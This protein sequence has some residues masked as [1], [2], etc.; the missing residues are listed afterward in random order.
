MPKRSAI[1][2]YA[3]HQAE[4]GKKMRKMIATF[5]AILTA[6]SLA[7]PI[8]ANAQT[9]TATSVPNVF[10]GYTTTYNIQPTYRPMTFAEFA[11]RATAYAR[12][13][14][15]AQNQAAWQYAI[16][17]P[18]LSTISN[19]MGINLSFVTNQISFKLNADHSAE[20]VNYP[21][22]IQ[23]NSDMVWYPDPF[24]L[25]DAAGN[26]YPTTSMVMGAVAIA[27]HTAQTIGV[28]FVVPYNQFG[29]L[30]SVQL[31]QNSF[32]DTPEVVSDFNTMSLD[33]LAAK[34]GI[35]NVNVWS[36]NSSTML[37]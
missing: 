8:T 7:L 37:Y 28:Q 17:N 18:Q 25:T 20:T 29:N 36:I 26:V 30:C 35:G 19:A 23:N 5:T 27:P 10:G 22:V 15:D 32:S 3:L 33:Q 1:I 31:S 6:F 11:A 14:Y 12:R 24:M 13:Q 34:Y 16:A 9:I 2:I 4:G 21:F